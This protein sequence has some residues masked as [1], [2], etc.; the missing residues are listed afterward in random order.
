VLPAYLPAA[1]RKLD[2]VLGTH[3]IERQLRA[4]GASIHVFGHSHINTRT[5]IDGVTYL[6]NAFGYP[7]EA[8]SHAKRLECV[9]EA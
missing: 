7:G 3:R 9:W 5:V 1:A 2:P 6:N 8:W 4:L